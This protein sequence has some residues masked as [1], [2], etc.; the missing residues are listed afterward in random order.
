[1]ANKGGRSPFSDSGVEPV[2]A[3]M[4]K[5]ITGWWHHLGTTKKQKWIKPEPT[6]LVN[7][8]VC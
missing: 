5:G 4:D 1:M 6:E 3:R 7:L 2:A 8:W